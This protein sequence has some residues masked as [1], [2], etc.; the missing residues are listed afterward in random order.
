MQVGMT[1]AHMCACSQL[2]HSIAFLTVRVLKQ[3]CGGVSSWEFVEHHDV[4]SVLLWLIA[5]GCTSRCLCVVSAVSHCWID[6]SNISQCRDNNMRCLSA[7]SILPDQHGSHAGGCSAAAAPRCAA[8]SSAICC[9]HS[10]PEH[11]AGVLGCVPAACAASAGPAAG[12]CARSASRR[13]LTHRLGKA[14]GGNDAVH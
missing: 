4:Q 12:S 3:L 10:C 9:F 7:G 11:A 8:H 2:T 5:D 6:I 14:V 1:A 13:L